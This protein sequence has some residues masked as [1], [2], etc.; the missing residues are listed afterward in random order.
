MSTSECTPNGQRVASLD[1]GTNSV[2]LLV[3]ERS[4]KGK[5]QR[6]FL[7]RLIVRLGDGLG[8]KGRLS[9][10]AMERAL[11]AL[12]LFVLKAG[13]LMACRIV[14]GGTWPLREAENSA[15]FL[16]KAKEQV[17]IDV[18]VLSERQEAFYMAKGVS[19]LWPSHPERWMAIDIGGGSTEVVWAQG[20]TPKGVRSVPL[21]MVV[22]TEKFLKNDPPSEGQIEACRQEIRRVLSHE[23]GEL[24]DLREHG[25]SLVGT[26]GTVTTL[27]AMDQGLREYHPDMINGYILSLEAVRGWRERLQRLTK[28][29]RTSIDGLERGRED[30][31]VAG[32]LIVEE[33]MKWLGKDA[34]IASDYGLLEGLAIYAFCREGGHE[35]KTYSEGDHVA[36]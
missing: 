24:H 27:A 21:G 12:K 29:E 35:D 10:D 1:I 30:V 20:G 23:L 32:A 16:L 26:A 3:A 25:F 7:E 34:L 33:V 14:A 31:I 15:L 11:K 36:G 9:E 2:R 4:Q 22:L 17:G 5:I 13:E 8:E 18:E 19:M 28:K 6:V